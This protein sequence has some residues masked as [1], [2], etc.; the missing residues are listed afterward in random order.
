MTDATASPLAKQMAYSAVQ[1]SVYGLWRSLT[2]LRDIAPDA[3]SQLDLEL[4]ELLD[5]HPA[6][7]TNKTR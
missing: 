6:M 2:M 4:L 5:E 7:R 3:M 1:D